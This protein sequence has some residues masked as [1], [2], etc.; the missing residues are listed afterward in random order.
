MWFAPSVSASWRRREEAAD[1]DETIS[2]M[3]APRFGGLG[4][5]HKT[6]IKNKK[7]KGS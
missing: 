6:K 4:G 7:Q 2:R 1:I 3:K 5:S